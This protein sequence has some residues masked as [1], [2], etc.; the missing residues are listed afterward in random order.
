MFD[1]KRHPDFYVIKPSGQGIRISQIHELADHLALKPTFAKKRVVIVK[2]AHK[3]NI[4]SANAFLKLLEEP[5]L[6][7]LIVLIAPDEQYLLETI[8]SRCQILA[9]ET[10]TRDELKEIYLENYEIKEN[11]LAFL[12]NYSQGRIRKDVLQKLSQLIPMRDQILDMV[13]TLSEEQMGG[14]CVSLDKWV[15]NDMHLFFIEFLSIIFRDI[16]CQVT[17][18]EGELI[19]QDRLKEIKS[20]ASQFSSEAARWCFD[21]IIETETAIKANA[22]RA[23]ALE[24]LLIQ[25]KQIKQGNIV[26]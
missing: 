14:Y 21:L 16:I 4:E 13:Q 25:L 2:D 8:V 1:Q 6:D 9:F 7:T 20:L 26:V 17:G 10:L 11:D 12:L 24:S 18:I 23:L 15:K 19:N 22:S 3:L 5:P